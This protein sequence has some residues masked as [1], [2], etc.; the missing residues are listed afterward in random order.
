M[1]VDIWLLQVVWQ[2]SIKVKFLQLC[3]VTPNCHAPAA[4]A[5]NPVSRVITMCNLHIEKMCNAT[6]RRYVEDADD[7]RE[8]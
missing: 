5:K 8:I 2:E 7:L 3:A 4:A 6:A 1:D